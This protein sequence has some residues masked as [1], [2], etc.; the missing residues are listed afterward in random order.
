LQRLCRLVQ[1]CEWQLLFDHCF[2]SACAG[3]PRG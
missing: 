2:R 1:L 3:A